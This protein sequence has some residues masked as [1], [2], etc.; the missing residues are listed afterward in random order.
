M[1]G[2]YGVV[3]KEHDSAYG[4]WFPDVEGC[5][6]ASDDESFIHLD[7]AKALIMHLEPTEEYPVSRSLEDIKNDPLVKEHLQEGAYIDF[8]TYAK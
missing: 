1:F 5:F 7:A 8:F 2:Y 3:N 6:S 4:V